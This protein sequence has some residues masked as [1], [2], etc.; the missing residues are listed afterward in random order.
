VTNT[1]PGLGEM[2]EG[3]MSIEVYVYIKFDEFNALRKTV[4][5]Q[6]KS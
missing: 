5:I 3:K 6:D 2:R 4:I 1:V